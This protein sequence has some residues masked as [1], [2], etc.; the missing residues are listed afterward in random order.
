[1]HSHSFINPFIYQVQFINKF[2]KFLLYMKAY[3]SEDW[4]HSSEQ[5]R[6]RQCTQR[7]LLVV[8]WLRLHALNAGGPGAIP[9]QGPRSHMWL[10]KILGLPLWLGSKEPTYNVGDTGSIPGSGRSPGEGNGNPHIS[11]LAWEIPWTGSLA[12][13]SP[14][15]HKGQIW[16]KQ[17]SMHACIGEGNGNPLQYSCLENSRDRGAW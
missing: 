15:G 13:Y 1:M 5:D 9:G 16:L 6:T 17:L 2:I 12:G 11:I 10:L 14:W 4:E 7:T 8:Q 3:C